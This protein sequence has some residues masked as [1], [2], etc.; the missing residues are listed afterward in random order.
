M[1][2]DTAYCEEEYSWVSP[3]ISSFGDFLDQL[4]KETS[5][6]MLLKQTSDYNPQRQKQENK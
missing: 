2:Y 6:S 3:G 1:R 4:K 5:K